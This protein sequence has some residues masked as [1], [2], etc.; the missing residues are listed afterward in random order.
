MTK[1]KK[2][3]GADPVSLIQWAIWAI[4]LPKFSM[5]CLIFSM[6]HI[7]CKAWTSK[8]NGRVDLL[9]LLGDGAE[10][11]GPRGVVYEVIFDNLLKELFQPQ[12][13][14]FT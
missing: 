10:D 11:L 12:M 5:S 7:F 8:N 13:V 1:V 3:I 14:Q 6:S 4:L 9:M 2:S